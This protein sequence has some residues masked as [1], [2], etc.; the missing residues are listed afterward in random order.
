MQWVKDLMNRVIWK[1]FGY[2]DLEFSWQDEEAQ[3]PIQVAQIDDI[4]VKSGVKSIDEVRI[5]LGLDPIG[6]GNAYMTATG[7]IPLSQFEN[8]NV[9]NP[10]STPQ[11]TAPSAG[12]P[13]TQANG[14]PPPDDAA[15]PNPEPSPVPSK[16]EAGAVKL[17]K[18]GTPAKKS[19]AP[20]DR[21][22]PAV[23]D[24]RAALTTLYTDFFKKQGALIA[25]QV[26]AALGKADDAGARLQE[27][28]DEID[29]KGWDVLVAPTAQ[30]LE[31]ITLGAARLVLN[32]L[33]LSSLIQD[34]S[35]YAAA[36]ARH[37]AA[38]MVGMR[39]SEADLLVP[40]HTSPVAPAVDATAPAVDATAPAVDA[41]APAVDAVLVPNP[42][43]KWAITDGTRNI[44][45]ALTVQ[46]TD[47]GW[48][49]AE[50]AAKIQESTAFSA[51]RADMIARTES[52]K[53]D[54]GGA[55]AGYR[56]SGVVSKKLWLV[57]EDPCD[58]CLANEAQGAI[59]L[60]DMFDS[61]DDAAPAHPRCECDIMPIV[62]DED[63]Q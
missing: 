21:N 3:D 8:G 22:R 1:Y 24:A 20:I 19:W 53:A 31:Q 63:T 44:L 2:N 40:D 30:E 9:P 27:V 50:F 23:R 42:D 5:A 34:A 29:F 39:W 37:R 26:T 25:A 43:A 33:D 16:D 57:A 12:A 61:G 55:M 13:L 48:S 35:I 47:L 36:F 56:A 45:R 59:P 41:T 38:E 15:P 18:G 60:D 10:L 11:A 52:A 6:M 14:E 46:A 17:A 28:I 62:D 58:V 4:Y 7:P 32:Q 54:V 51:S 49:T